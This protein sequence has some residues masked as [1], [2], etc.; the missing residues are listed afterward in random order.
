MTK[1]V[2][3]IDGIHGEVKIVIDEGDAQ[4]TMDLRW[5]V[6]DEDGSTGFLTSFAQA[7][8]MVTEVAAEHFIRMV[9]SGLV[10]A[11]QIQPGDLTIINH[12]G[13]HIPDVQFLPPTFKGNE[14]DISAL[15]LQQNSLLRLHSLYEESGVLDSNIMDAV[16]MEGIVDDFLSLVQVRASGIFLAV[17]KPSQQ[18]E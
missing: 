12:V 1:I 7:P 2:A 16:E 8:V 15:I 17:K 13:E 14:A 6:F 9:V 3:T 10:R 5:V 11:F 18:G 4:N